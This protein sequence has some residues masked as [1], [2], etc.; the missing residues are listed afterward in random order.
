MFVRSTSRRLGGLVA[1]VTA[2]LLAGSSAAVA[3]PAP[4]RGPTSGGTV[5]SGAV[6]DP[7]TFVDVVGGGRHTLALGA[8]GNTYAWGRG[9]EGQLGD[10]TTTE[11]SKPTAVDVPAG[12]TLTQVSA[13][14]EFSVAL[15]A[16]GNTYAWGNGRFGQRGEGSLESSVPVVLDVP[17]GVTFTQGAAGGEFSVALGADGNTYAWGNG[18]FGQL[19][20][21]SLESSVP[22]VVDVPAGV[23]FTQVAAGHDF[24]VA[25]GSDGKA[26]AW[27][28]GY[29]GQLGSA[30]TD[31]S[32]PV[33]VG[34]P[35]GVTLTQVAAG[36][37]HVVALG[38]DGN[39]YSWGFGMF[40]QLGN[41]TTTDSWATVTV[42]LPAGVTFTQVAAGDFHSLALGSDGNTYAWGYGTDGQL[43][44]GTVFTTSAVP[45]RVEVPAGVTFTQVAGG[46]SFSL[47]VGS[48]GQAY[49]WGFGS[50]GQ[51]GGG[52][53][54][55]QTPLPVAAA[56]PPGV[57][58]TRVTAD[59]GYSAALGSDGNAYAWGLG[60]DGQLGTGDATRSSVPMRVD[61]GGTTVQA[62]SFDGVAGTDLTV[63]GD[64][65]SVTTPA[66]A[67]GPVDVVVEHTQMGLSRSHRSAGGFTYGSAPVVTTHP[68]GADLP[69]GGGQVQLTAAADGDE[70]PAVQWQQAPAG[71]QEWTDV[72]GA[73]AAVLEAEVTAATDYRAVFTT[74]LG[75][76]ATDTAAVT[77]ARASDPEPAPDPEPVP[78]PDRTPA[79]GPAADPGTPAGDAVPGAAVAGAGAG[80]GSADVLARTGSDAALLAGL[81]LALAGAG[82]TL[83]ATRRRR[84]RR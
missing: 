70:T 66:H 59:H 46:A 69:P 48:D 15:G 32:V 75:S 2:C 62:V 8:D 21:G 3:A 35:A 61:T 77:V 45:V 4:D 74:C 20:E 36:Y 38:S 19:G 6:P 26:Y 30:L 42:D 76:A 10:G 81:A 78:G 22:V 73:T 31:S 23:T 12:V 17:A 67:C 68:V 13:G 82:A 40:G 63:D 25:L 34:L 71:T 43:G 60:D 41:G 54:S 58:V 11:V 84:A 64:T 79:P 14:G 55:P 24:S 29:F 51:L 52:A 5:V 27:G 50:Y 72:P 1:V 49:A 39:T 16:D 7:V 18:R 65:W 53:A 44:D 83:V 47:A 28:S 80:S 9:Q 57:T 37:G 33:P 56:L